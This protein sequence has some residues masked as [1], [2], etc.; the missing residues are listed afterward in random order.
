[1]YG[2]AAAVSKC[3]FATYTFA[4]A[5]ARGARGAHAQGRRSSCTSPTTRSSAASSARRGC[6]AQGLTRPDLADR[7]RLLRTR[8]STAHNGCLQLE[9]TVHGQAAHAALPETGV[10]A[11]QAAN[12]AADRAVRAQRRAARRAARRSRASPTRT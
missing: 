2:R 1:M 4:L 11:L 8:S 7:R 9:V 5:R 12:A 6:C 3:D 10:D